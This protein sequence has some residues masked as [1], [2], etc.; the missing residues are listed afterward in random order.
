MHGLVLDAGF[1][2]NGPVGHEAVARIEGLGT[3]LGIQ[4]DRRPAHFPGLGHQSREQ[5]IAY[6]FA[7][8]VAQHRHATDL[9]FRGQPAGA[10]GLAC[11]V[12]GNDMAA[13]WVQRVPF[14][15]QRDLLLLHEHG[16]THGTQLVLCLGVVDYF[17][18]ETGRRHQ[19][20]S[21]VTSW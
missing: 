1:L 6:A 17:N 19:F 12:A 15:L 14:L 10:D 3:D 16:L 13:Q 11:L 2:E 20:S 4:A 21:S 7:A 18:A 5:G 9:A 8:P